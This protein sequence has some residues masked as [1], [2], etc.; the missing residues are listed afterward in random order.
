MGAHFDPHVPGEPFNSDS[1]LFTPSSQ[2]TH[3]SPG[4]SIAPKSQGLRRGCR[5]PPATRDRWDTPVTAQSPSA[6][7][8]CSAVPW[9]PRT[10]S[11]E[12]DTVGL[13]G[14]ACRVCRHRPWPCSAAPQPRGGA[15]SRLSGPAL[16]GLWVVAAA[17]PGHAWGG[18][19]GG[20]VALTRAGFLP[21][22]NLILASFHSAHLTPPIFT[23]TAP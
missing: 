22:T 18:W 4:R 7:Q 21:G 23:R 20:T 14:P 9:S 1:G 5:E 13:P 11:L 17:F 16:C 2:G 10:P 12:W 8:R 15:G 19:A 3:G 6:G